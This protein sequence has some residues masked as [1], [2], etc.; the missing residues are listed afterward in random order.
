MLAL[1]QRRVP[2]VL[3][4]LDSPSL[5]AE[6]CTGIDV[7]FHVAGHYPRLSLDLP[8]ALAAGLR[9]LE[10][11]LDAAA[12]AG[13]KRVVYVSSTATVAPHSAGRPS[14]EAD[15]FGAAPAFGT[16]H[17]LKWA[18]E[19]RALR[20]D[21]LELVV[22]CPAACLGPWDLR[23]GTSA[24][25]VATAR[26]ASVP[27]PDGVVS[28]VDARDVALAL[29]RL[30]LHPAPPRRLLLSAASPR[31]QPLLGLLARRYGAPPPSPPLSDAEA[32]AFCDSEELRASREGGRP[33]LA[34][35]LAD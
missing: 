18:M 30:G 23:V 3:A 11:V 21:R 27:H 22:A 32:L 2:L 7:V 19:A 1:R 4:D 31:L 14:T 29:L 8:G 6:A 26:G 35:E 24:L 15:L 20:E 5:L 25:L 28:W 12:A 16:Y 13:V 17:A 9:Q 33:A 10:N 34:R